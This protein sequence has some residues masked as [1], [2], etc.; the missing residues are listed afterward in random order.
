[1][2]GTGARQ[3][4]RVLDLAVQGEVPLR[5]PVFEAVRGLG[6]EAVMY[7]AGA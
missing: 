2:Q 6:R 3:V 7:T 5:T 1:M 4:L